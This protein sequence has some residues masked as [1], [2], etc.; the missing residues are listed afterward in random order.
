M[1]A[2]EA[3]R[4][5]APEAEALWRAWTTRNDKSARDRLVMAYAPMVK[6]LASKKVRELPTHCE[7]DDLVSCLESRAI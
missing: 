3:R 1:T 4:L 6:Y 7:L 2:T 5:T